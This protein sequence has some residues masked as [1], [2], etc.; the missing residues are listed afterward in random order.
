MFL[1]SLVWHPFDYRTSKDITFST[2]PIYDDLGIRFLETN[3]YGFDLN[4]QLVYTRSE[5]VPYDFLVVA[6][7]TQ[8]YYNSV[9]GF[10]PGETAWSI[11]S[12]TESEKTKRAWRE[13]L[14]NPGPI[15]I[16]A[17]QWASYFFVAYEF[18]FN[19]LY[20]LKEHRILDKAP[21]HFVTSEPYL[22]HFGIGGIDN[23]SQKCEEFLARYNVKWHT[24]AM[25]RELKKNQVVLENG[26]VI[27][28][29]FSLIVPQ[30]IGIDPVRATRNFADRNGLIE[31]NEEF[32][33][34]NYPNI[35]AAGGAVKI[36]QKHETP[37]PCDVP[38]T[39]NSSE[40]MA[41]TIAYNIASEIQGGSRVSVSTER[42]YEYCRQDMEHI[43]HILFRNAESNEHD[44]DFIAKGSQNKWANISIEQYID[45][46]FDPEYLRI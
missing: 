12:M 20:H 22:T 32:R 34:I 9:K 35:F 10:V 25:I 36:E 27:D 1:P 4:E 26:E 41:K 30:F 44:L 45:A 29:A 37:V 31:V 42:I 18:M 21:L 46:S 43:G 3:V 2:K 14:L 38:R 33:H 11:A 15:V 6:T 40:V 28:S 8:P 13:F 16:G 5:D 39:R 23:G 24:N 7:G 17:S 19:A